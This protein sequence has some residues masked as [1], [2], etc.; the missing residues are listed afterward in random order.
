MKAFILAAG[1]GSRLK[2]WTEHHPKA[3]VD[4]AG[5]P[6]LQRVIENVVDAGISDIIINIHHFGEQIIDF[7]SNHKF[8]ANITISDERDRLLDTGGGLR[9]I[10]PILN[11]EPV[12]VHNADIL[13]DYNLRRLISAHDE[14]Q[15][16]A[17]L[18][19]AP[20]KSNRRLVFN[21]RMKLEGWINLDTK[22]TKPH[23]FTMPDNSHLYCFNGIH[24]LNPGL[25]NTLTEYQPE[26]TPFSIIDFYINQC[27][28]SNIGGKIIDE[29]AHWFDVGKPTTLQE[30]IR[31]MLSINQP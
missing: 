3:L 14:N 28:Q 21:Q 6:M 1:I 24:I 8:K 11:Q 16:D 30:A 26:S 12:L 17:T 20:R 13:T 23:N 4:I 15:N 25:Y 27:R 10:I 2:P 29:D 22:E 5:K 18:L 31:Y 7:I 9:K 19:I